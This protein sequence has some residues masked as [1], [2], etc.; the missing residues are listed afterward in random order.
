MAHT[1]GTGQPQEKPAVKCWVINVNQTLKRDL[2]M[3]IMR[4]MSL[5]KKLVFLL[6]VARM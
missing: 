3:R 2:T 5:R 1:R 6:H 4:M